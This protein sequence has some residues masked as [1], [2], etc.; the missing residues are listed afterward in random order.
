MST[1]LLPTINIAYAGTNPAGLPVATGVPFPQ[2]MLRP[3]MPLT[4]EAPSGEL[5]PAAGW[6][7]SSPR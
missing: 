2:G 7:M 1:E 5:H 3:D 4:V 6:P